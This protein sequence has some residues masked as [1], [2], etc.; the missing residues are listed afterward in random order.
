MRT[1]YGQNLL[2]AVSQFDPSFDAVNYGAR[3]STRKEF[4][5]GK[6]S[7]SVNA[8][9]TVA[10]HLESL[11]DAADKLG[12]TSIPMVNG[13]KNWLA[14]N[15]RA[16]RAS[17]SSTA[18]KK[19]VV[20]ELTRVWRGNGGSEGDIKTWSSTLDAANSPQQLHGVIAQMGELVGS[21]INSM[22]EQYRQGMGTTGEPLQLLT[23]KAQK[24][25]EKLQQRAG[26]EPASAAAPASQPGAQ[27]RGRQD[28]RERRQGLVRGALRCRTTSPTTASCRS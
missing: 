3:A 4:T 20:D 13:V 12:N 8:M 6:A 11:S 17:S 18:T 9:N 21:K 19:A 15:A 7:Q 5:S 26:G 22:G 10:G 16:I 2:N 25:F 24:V 28:V 23:P 27:E 14:S 1:P